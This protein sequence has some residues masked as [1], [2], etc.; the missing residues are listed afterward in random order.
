MNYGLPYMGSKNRI[1][2]W[3]VDILPSS[4]RLY[5][6]FAGGCAITHCAMLSGKWNNYVINDINPGVTQLFLD[7]MDGKYKDENRWISRED[8]F[9]LKDDDPFV[10]CCWSFGNDWKTYMYG[11]KIEPYKKACHYAIVFDD[12]GQYAELCP[13]TVEAAKN[14]VE[15][16]T[17][18]RERRLAFGPSVVKRLKE[19]NDETLLTENPLYKSVKR[20]SD[21]KFKDLESFES[22]ESLERINSL[23]HLQSLQSLERNE[24][25]NSIM[26]LQNQERLERINSIYD[27]NP[28]YKSTVANNNIKIQN[29]INNDR[30][31]NIYE[32]NPF[33]KAI[34]NAKSHKFT[35]LLSTE[36]LQNQ[37][38]LER[39]NS[40]SSTIKPERLCLDYRDVGITPNSTVYC[41][42]PYIE[43]GGYNVGFNHDEFYEWALS[44]PFDVYISEYSMPEGF[45]CIGEK[46]R[47]MSFSKKG[48]KNTTEKIFINR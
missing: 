16:L 43:K 40:I 35:S 30:V 26:R 4:D 32:V 46:T 33:Y 41:D 11:P 6:L 45:T 31:N 29:L 9:K 2:E 39:I 21:G 24:R 36:R 27:V 23:I 34:E 28:L 5:D 44:R 13:E 18:T 10:A 12:W 19:L 20:K 22:M 37:E 42:I 38:R 3:V 15:G 7:A 25:I 48:S 14:A 1:A 17:D 8:F 47:L